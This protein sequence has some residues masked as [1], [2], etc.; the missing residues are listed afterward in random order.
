MDRY[1]D[2]NRQYWLEF[3]D[4]NILK[5]SQH[6]A[7]FISAV[8]R[9]DTNYRKSFD[10]NNDLS[11]AFYIHH[12]SN[13]FAGNEDILYE[14][15]KRI[16]RENSTHL[17]VSGNHPGDNRGIELMSIGL[18]QITHL[19]ER[20]FRGDGQLVNEISRLVD[21]QN[22]FSFATKFCASMC[23]YLFNGKKA[24][25]YVRYDRYIA[26]ILP[27]YLWKHHVGNENYIRVGR[28]HYKST[29]ESNFKEER[30]Y[31]GF[32]ELIDRIRIAAAID[33]NTETLSR[34]EFDAL[35]WYYYKGSD[36]EIENALR[37]AARE[38]T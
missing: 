25:N 11:A 34:E 4:N 37:I 7:Q 27:Y 5:L 16:D 6:N 28:I 10:E 1:F 20:L 19:R 36:K 33:N 18:S 3:D 29:I 35:V 9:I 12:H 8:V 38:R 31:Q 24:D 26:E 32:K 17:S 30:D 13:D 23:R 2:N 15:C 21:G 14:I 22:K